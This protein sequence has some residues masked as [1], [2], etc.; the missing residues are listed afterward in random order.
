MSQTTAAGSSRLQPQY[1]L[2][3]LWVGNTLRMGL[4]PEPVVVVVLTQTIINGALEPDPWA[5]SKRI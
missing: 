1:Q 3:S 5:R 4:V 2:P